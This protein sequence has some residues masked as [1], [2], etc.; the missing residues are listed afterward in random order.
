MC[1]DLHGN[2][3]RVDDANVSRVVHR[4]ARIHDTAEVAAHHRCARHF[5]VDRVEAR[6]HAGLVNPACPVDVRA[7]IAVVRDNLESWDGFSVG[8]SEFTVKYVGVF[9][10]IVIGESKAT[11]ASCWL[12]STRRVSRAVAI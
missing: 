7:T 11:Y 5:V 12:E 6:K 1:T 8:T 9:S 4:E 10:D 2:D 3:R